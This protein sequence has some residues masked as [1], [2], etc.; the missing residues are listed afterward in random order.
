MSPSPEL[1]RQVAREMEE[2][3]NAP[4]IVYGPSVPTCHFCGQIV[5]EHERTPAHDM[6]SISGGAPVMV[7]ER[8]R[9]RCCGG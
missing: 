1:I 9:G 8:Y 7:N 4:P 6:L 3:R 5:K 2:I